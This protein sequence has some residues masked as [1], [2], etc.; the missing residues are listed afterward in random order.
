LEKLLR[1]SR[2][3]ATSWHIAGWHRRC[4]SATR[5]A[6]RDIGWPVRGLGVGAGLTADELAAVARLHRVSALVDLRI[7]GADERVRGAALGIRVLHLP[8]R[9][10]CPVS[11]RALALGVA[12]V[13]AR[14]RAGEVVYIHCEHGIGRSALLAACVLVSRGATA[15]EAL[16]TLKRAR[17][18]VSP[19]RAQLRA[20]LRWSR[21]TAGERRGGESLADLTRIA[22]MSSPDAIPA[23]APAAA[24]AAA[25]SAASS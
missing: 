24:P 14:L 21:R 5:M 9:D 25:R 3:H 10:G 20:L 19:S 6:M 8:T 11:R 4:A 15:G 13:N 23:V 17:P 1:R 7:E 22:W 12:W 18:V 16:R 2:G